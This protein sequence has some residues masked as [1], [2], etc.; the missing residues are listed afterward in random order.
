M[1]FFITSLIILFGLS[2][3]SISSDFKVIEKHNFGRVDD[4]LLQII[5][6]RGYEFVM[7][8]EDSNKGQCDFRDNGIHQLQQII[9]EEGGGKKC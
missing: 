4:G 9:T 5:C 2:S 3:P 1:R 7:I 8:C 6:L